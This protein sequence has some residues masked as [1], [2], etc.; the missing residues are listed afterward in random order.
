MTNLME[1]TMK[2]LKNKAV[3]AGIPEEV[4]KSFTTKA[5]VV[6]VIQSLE[7]K[8][9]KEKLIDQSK[10]AIETPK[11]KVHSDKAWQSKRDRMG[12]LL[13]AQ[14]KVGMLLQLEPGEKA[15]VVESRVVNG[16]REFKVISGS[17]HEKIINGYKWI[18]PKGVMTQVP[19]QISELVS[20]GMNIMATLGVKKS[21]DRIDPNTG[22]PVRDALR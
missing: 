3:K 2:E 22:K 15:G 8:N 14:P 13:E 1:L 21:I 12:R 6:G 19:Q 10:S 18:M 5:Q 11:E 16:I 4:A 9:L 7:S 17:I 20:R